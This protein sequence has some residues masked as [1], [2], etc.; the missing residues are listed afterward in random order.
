MTI[1]QKLFLDAINKITPNENGCKI[2]PIKTVDRY[3]AIWLDGK[4]HKVHR[5]LY[6]ILK[7]KNLTIDIEVRHTCDTPKCCNIEH[8]VEGTHQENMSDM[9]NRKKTK[10][11]SGELNGSSKLTD[12]QIK[13]IRRLYDSGEITNKSKLSRMFKCSDV[14]VGLVV[15]N[16]NRKTLVY[17]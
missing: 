4:K 5:A 1:H 10:H 12:I 6:C 2:W 16:K 17:I 13:E 3:G 11:Y 14:L 8:L 7:E 15:R 9:V